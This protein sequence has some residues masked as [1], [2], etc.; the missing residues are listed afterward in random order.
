MKRGRT[1]GQ[2]S[3]EQYEET[4]M[5]ENHNTGSHVCSDHPFPLSLIIVRVPFFVQHQIQLLLEEL[6][7]QN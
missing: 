3:K 7:F 5:L 4:S 6:S 2:L 1:D